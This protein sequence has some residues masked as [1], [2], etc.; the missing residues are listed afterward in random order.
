MIISRTPFRVSFFGGGTDYPDWYREHGGA[1]IAVAIAK[2]CYLSCRWFQNFFDA[3]HRIVYNRIELCGAIDEIEHPSVRACLRHFGVTDGVEIIHNADLPARSG[4]G[5][6][7]SFTIGLLNALQ[8]LT[9]RPQL[10]RQA[11]ADLAIHLEQEVMGESVGSQ[12]QMMA[13]HGGLN[14][15]SFDAKGCRAHPLTLPQERLENLERHMLLFWTGLS[16]NASEI[17][18]HQIGNIG[19][20]QP[21]L[22]AMLHL[23]DQAEDILLGSG[24]WG[25]MGRL[26]HE[27]WTIKRGLSRHITSDQIDA[28][29]HTARAHGA[30]GGKLLGAGGGGFFL[31]LARPEDHEGI[32]AALS[33]LI[34][35]PVKFDHVGSQ[36]IFQSRD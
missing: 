11:L 10:G 35:T 2:Y 17:A 4:L 7:S 13:A 9:A 5:S 8:A 20:K 18:A 24:D 26:M 32:R 16:R 1:V 14:R 22:R 3:K 19:H 23:V 28:I 21:E 36:I 34:C 33:P 31:V 12:D 29:Y 30:L 25:E 15:L 6:S 27:S